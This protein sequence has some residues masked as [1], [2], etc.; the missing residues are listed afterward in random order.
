MIIYI[1]IDVP[2]PLES[3]GGGFAQ[4]C[5]EAQLQWEPLDV[6]ASSCPGLEL[7]SHSSASLLA[8]YTTLCSTG[9]EHPFSIAVSCL[10]DSADQQQGTNNNTLLAD[11]TEASFLDQLPK[12]KQ[13]QFVLKPRLQAP[14][15]LRR[16]RGCRSVLQPGRDFAAFRASAKLF[17]ASYTYPRVGVIPECVQRG[18]DCRGAEFV[19]ANVQN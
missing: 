13:C 4:C 7:F 3:T 17:L 1:C 15:Q 11:G 6:A 2:W 10:R 5:I 18:R 14:M 12:E 9:H 8:L 19:W 16:G